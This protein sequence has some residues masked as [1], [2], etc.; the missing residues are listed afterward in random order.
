MLPTSSRTPTRRLRPLILLVATAISTAGLTGV[1]APGAQSAANSVPVTVRNTT[2]SSA[3][4]YLYLLGVD[5]TSAD[6]DTLGYVNAQGVFRAWPKV[7]GS[8]PRP[9]PDVAIAGPRSGKSV[10]LKLPRGIS[11]RLYYSIGSKLDLK[12]VADSRG[13]SR[14]VQPAPWVAGDANYSKLFDWTEFTY[15][16]G[17]WINSTQVDQF[18]L[19]AAISVTG[20][21]GRRST[22][23]LVSGGR[24]K[25]INSML[26][27]PAFARS[28]VKNSSGRVLRVLS[29]GH[30]TRSGRLIAAYLDK[31][32]AR[33]WSRALTVR[34][35]ENQPSLTYYGRP[36]GSTMVFRTKSGAV[37]ARFAKPSTVD[38]FE[39]AG[40]LA[41]PN[42]RVVGPIAR[43]L[44]AA[45]NRGTLA[46][47]SVEPVADSGRYY[48]SNPMNAYAKAVHAAMANRRA[49]AFP[50]DD[51]AQQEP[52]LH[53]ARP[54]SITI[55]IPRI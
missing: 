30:A 25:V 21:S 34:P 23:A 4:M 35:F 18:A 12:L 28:V 26:A 13:R 37:V 22:G 48:R 16:N 24:K 8:A 31:A 45:L 53:D 41:A 52:L 3:R 19:P 27:N 2:G 36:Q 54:R 46:S 1:S 55:T 49:Y 44:C 40:T 17:I 42:D 29:A 5:L 20:A 14:L 9:A 33:A 43:T 47:G 39:C 11:G 7:S 32:I 38:A 6:R 50:F 15:D 10:T 51:V